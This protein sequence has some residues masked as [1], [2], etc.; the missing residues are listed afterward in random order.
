MSGLGHTRGAGDLGSEASPEWRRSTRTYG[1]T[2]CVEVAALPGE[3]IDVR[4][5]K[6]PRGAV[7]QFTSADWKAFVAGVRYDRFGG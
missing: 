2:N 5:S 7:L 6:N 1:G 3:R 4:D